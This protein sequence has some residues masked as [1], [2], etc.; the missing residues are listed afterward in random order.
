MT[1]D[2]RRVRPKA[3]LDAIEA[4]VA[5][6]F[7]GSVWRVVTNGYDPLRPGPAGGRWDDGTFDVLY[8]STARDGALAEAWFHASQG[9]PVV[10]SKPRKRLHRLEAALERTLDLT[11]DRL[12]ALGVNMAAYGRLSYIQRREEYPR[13]QQIA[14]A[15]FF[16]E[17]EAIVVPNARWPASNVVVFTENAKPAQIAVVGD[18]AVDLAAWGRRLG[19]P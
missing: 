4:E 15:A 16:Y 5:R 12:A 3:L 8:T 17:Y 13:L 9:Q 2:H 11:G 14:E 7:T 1:P 19:R 10:P 18:E 6:P